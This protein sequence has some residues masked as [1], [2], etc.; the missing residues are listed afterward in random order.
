MML[1]LPG[2][3]HIGGKVKEATTHLDDEWFLLIFSARAPA[4]P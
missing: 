1:Q 4:S 3:I 2:L